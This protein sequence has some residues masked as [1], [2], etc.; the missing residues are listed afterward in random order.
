M[1]GVGLSTPGAISNDTVPSE[2]E[3]ADGGRLATTQLTLS[4]MHCSACAARI[5][6]ALAGNP[7]VTAASVN[8]ATERAFVAFDPAID[9][10]DLCA[11]VDAAGYSASVVGSAGVEN[12][13]RQDTEH[14]PL[15]VAISW[16]LALTALIVAFAAPQGTMAGWIVLSLAIAVE[17]IGGWPFLKTTVRLLRHGGTSMDTLIAVGTVAALAVSAIEALALGGQHV[18]FGGPGAFAARLHGVMAPLIVAVLATGRYIEALARRRAASAMHSLMSLRPPTARLISDPNDQDGQLVP[19]E[20]V[21]VGS[22]VRIRPGESIPLDGIVVSGWSPIDESMLTGES[23]PIDRGPGSH[24]TG[25]TRNGAGSIVISV[26]AI[27]SESV[28]T[29]MQRLVDAAQRD[30]PP[31]QRMAD[32]ISG[33]FVPVILVLALVTFLLWWLV[34]GNLGTALLSGVAVLLVACP[35]AM[36]LATPVAMMVGTARAAA[37][38]VLFHSGDALER[39]AH[40]GTVAFDKT[41][42]LTERHAVVTGVAAIPGVD[43]DRILSSAA[44]VEAE[45][46]HPIASAIRD[47]SPNRAVA[48]QVQMF[49]GGGVT[50]DLDG[51]RISIGRPIIESLPL[52]LGAAFDAHTER[53][54]TVVEVSRDE[55]VLGIIAV[56]TPVRDDAPPAVQRLHRMGLKTTILSGDAEP[57]VGFVARKTLIESHRSGLSPEDKLTALRTLQSG[58]QRV[59]MVGDGVNDAPALAAADVGCAVGSGSETALANS[60]VALIGSDLRGVPTAIA[61]TR[62]ILAVI[63]QNFGWAMGYNISAIPLAAAGLL[64]PLVAA[65]AMGVSSLVVVLNSLRLMRLGRAGRTG[66]AGVETAA[67]RGAVHRIRRFALSVAVPI[68]LFAGVTTV[69]EAVSPSRGQPLLPTLPSITDVSMAHGVTAQV[70]LQSSQAG[71][72]QFHVIFVATSGG[73]LPSVGVPSATA[74]RTSESVMPLRLARLSPRHYI[75]YSVFGPGTWEFTVSVRVDGQRHAFRV[76]RLLS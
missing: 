41:G 37:S 34:D 59:V 35:C 26:E 44:S 69:A 24:V 9:P 20:T 67:S 52:E 72:N 45:I 27:A 14:W 5:E 53:G 7:H 23:L 16:P 54:D 13:Q 17:L 30:K 25:G 29:R 57:A 60:D 71:V 58:G 50:G 32:R 39:L 18:H 3:S 15:R 12:H 2:D 68:L 10:S 8:L 61:M 62:S 55:Q 75:A 43:A 1:A 48:D 21:P 36:G 4:G 42:T 38:G 33:V 65:V 66:G 22:L 74:S 19:P 73:P 6:R 63:V 51:H 46:D 56:A 47:A 70:Y 11:T 64:D 40:S 31:L 49:A 28:L 76:T